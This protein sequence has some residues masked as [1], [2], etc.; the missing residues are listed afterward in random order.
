MSNNKTKE[1]VPYGVEWQK[2]VA[3]LN[4][5]QLVAMLRKAL[6]DLQQ[7]APIYLVKF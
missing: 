5:L 6:M 1:Y 3:K 4:K 2:E 7:A